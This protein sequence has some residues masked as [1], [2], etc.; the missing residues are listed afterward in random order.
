MPYIKCPF[1]E[2]VGYAAPTRRGPDLCPRCGAA[3][4]RPCQVVAV[5]RHQRSRDEHRGRRERRPPP[6]LAYQT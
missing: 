5:S 3:L 2:K 4:P 1:C 6:D